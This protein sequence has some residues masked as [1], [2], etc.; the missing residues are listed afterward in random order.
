MKFLASPVITRSVE[1]G[2]CDDRPPPSRPAYIDETDHSKWIAIVI[3]TKPSPKTLSFSALDN[4]IELKRPD[5]TRDNICDGALFY[6]ETIIFI[7][8][9]QREYS[10]WVSSGY[11]QL[12]QTIA[13]FE[14]SDEAKPFHSRMA[15]IANKDRPE[16][17]RGK[18]GIMEQFSRDTGYVLRIRNRV[19][20]G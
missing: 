17:E 11:E 8:L 16:A 20:I 19:E 6:E 14:A 13:H 4:V 10:G 12:K 18:M 3:N 15:Y 2:I 5:G 9:K 1:F 7:E